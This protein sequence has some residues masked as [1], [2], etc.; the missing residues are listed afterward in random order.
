M[1]TIVVPHEITEMCIIPVKRSKVSHL[2]LV[3][4]SDGVSIELLILLILFYFLVKLVL[5][6]SSVGLFTE[7]IFEFLKN[8]V[9][10]IDY[11]IL[12]KI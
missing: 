12:L 2:L 6:I 11:D 1:K 7:F 9:F 5:F 3:A 4:L 10:C 8:E